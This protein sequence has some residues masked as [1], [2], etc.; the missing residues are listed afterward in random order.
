MK[1]CFFVTNLMAGGGKVVGL[2]LLKS[3]LKI[4]AEQ[5]D[6]DLL[7]VLPNVAEYRRVWEG[8]LLHGK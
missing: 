7:A 5:N 4:Q 2:N 6:F 1:F 3:F 8:G